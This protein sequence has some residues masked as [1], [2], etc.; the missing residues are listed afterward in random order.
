[1]GEADYSIVLGGEAG[2]GIQT[3]EQ[4]LTKALKLS[5]YHVFST[6]EYMSRVRGGANTTEIRVSSRPVNC[7]VDRIDLFVPL[8]PK[9][10]PRQKHRFTDD[11][12]MLGD[13]ESL[14]E[15]VLDVPFSE[16]AGEVGD[17]IYTNMVAVGVLAGLFQVDR[18]L[19]EEM[20][21]ERFRA[22]SDEIAEGN[23]KA[24]NRGCDIAEKLLKEGEVKVGV[25]RA[26]AAKDM[27]LKGS[28]AVA[29]GAVAG[30]CNFIAAYP[31]S[32]STAV[33]NFMAAHQH[34]FGIVVEQAED[35]IAA[36]NMVV[37]AWYAGARAMANTSGGGFAL[38]EEGVSLAGMLESPAV[39]H[40]A[41]RPGPATGLPT[42]TAQEDLELVL[43]SGHGEFPR[44]ILAP[45]TLE[46][47]FKLARKA[48][49]LADKHQV[50]VFLLTDQYYMDS[51]YNIPALDAKPMVE[52]HIVETSEGYRR[53]DL[54]SSGVSP[55]GI[56]GY[57][58]GLV[59]VDS[60]EH[61]MNGHITEDLSLRVEMVD[62]RLKKLNGIME[63]VL[64][65]E[66]IGQ[67]DYKTL[68][69]CWGT[70]R[71]VVEEALKEFDD[72]SALHF[73]QVHPVHDAATEYL[74][75]AEEVVSLEN[76]ATAQFA[77]Q[78]KMQTGY[79]VVYTILKYDG[80]PFS[81]EEVVEKIR[82]VT[83]Q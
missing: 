28:E 63:D 31:M 23:K 69:V 25:K 82:E 80:L 45:G 71:N 79:E 54:A 7:H 44:I 46:Q 2:Q 29:L 51:Y 73:T 49:N 27:L 16:I 57:G 36:I 1:M 83:A 67:K 8:D 6:K 47:G 20:I 48:F 42:R 38:M 78:L 65:P 33:L 32:P 52:R 74:D 12:V 40:V 11:T 35:E 26:K 15:D 72:V 9:V 18:R 53:Y 81:V 10:I 30:G 61:D 55:R 14:G 60:D 70:T 56:P 34:D 37:G 66:L 24:V 13:K 50:P 41:Q 17:E 39:I 62:K 43:Y 75:R 58:E 59:C 21:E 64:K 5:G 77:K 76:N 19:L 3:V 22:K 68:V 4:F